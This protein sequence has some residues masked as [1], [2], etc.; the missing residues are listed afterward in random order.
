MNET[1]SLEFQDKYDADHSL[2]YFHK[3]NRG[4]RRKLSNWV[5]H[6]ML[7]K[8]LRMAGDPASVLDLPCGTGRFWAL[9]ARR[10]DRR[11]LAADYSQS[12]ID[13]ACRYR[14]PQLVARFEC[15]QTSAF[16]IK[17]ADNAVENIVC[18]RL[19]HHIGDS[20][21]RRRILDQFHR[22]ASRSVIFSC[23][24]GCNLQAKRRKKL[25]A[26]RG[27][28]AYQN[29]FVFES[30]TIETEIRAAGFNIIGHVDMLPGIS[31]WRAYVL[32]KT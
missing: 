14:G 3:H 24:V 27:K 11:L 12:M 2:E 16:D 30:A 28:R 25:E 1:K 18:M 5:E 13:A 6:R 10:A 22:V 29:R 19:L 17:Q 21:D 31:M 4:L 15:F 9:L 32:R 23:W 20:A 26:L 7:A 8:A